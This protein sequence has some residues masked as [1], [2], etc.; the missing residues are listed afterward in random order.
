[1]YNFAQKF[2]RWRHPYSVK[3]LHCLVETG[4]CMV[5]KNCHNFWTKLD[6]NVLFSQDVRYNVPLYVEHSGYAQKPEQT[7]IKIRQKPEIFKKTGTFQKN[8]NMKNFRIFFRFLKG[9][10]MKYHWPKFEC[11]SIIPSKVIVICILVPFGAKISVGVVFPMTSSKFRKKNS[12][13][14][15]PNKS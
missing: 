9:L 4:K 14:I 3:P 1:M 13:K 6:I 12:K 2:L 11:I 7:G 8:R 15:F 5:D 10:N